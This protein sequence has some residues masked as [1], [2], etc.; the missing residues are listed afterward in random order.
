MFHRPLDLP[1]DTFGIAFIVPA[2]HGLSLRAMRPDRL[3]LRHRRPT[4]E[5]ERADLVVRL[6]RLR[7]GDVV[8]RGHVQRLGD[9]HRTPQ[10]RLRGVLACELHDDLALRRLRRLEANPVKG[11]FER[12]QD[13][14]APPVAVIGDRHPLGQTEFL[15][16]KS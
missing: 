3:P 5:V 8:S 16:S 15:D 12:F 13:R 6:C 4:G 11:R 14:D 7:L 10:S 9:Q 1:V 2:Q